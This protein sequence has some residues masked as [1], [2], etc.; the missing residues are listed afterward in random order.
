MK[1]MIKKDY[2]KSELTND[3]IVFLINF[4]NQNLQLKRTMKHIKNHSPSQ[5]QT[6][7]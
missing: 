2:I 3:I 4:D 1:T 5:N 6:K 7:S